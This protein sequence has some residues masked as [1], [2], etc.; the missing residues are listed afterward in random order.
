ML[1][2]SLFRVKQWIKNG[3][4]LVPL[5]FA[6]QFEDW[7]C[8]C[9]T[10]A[11]FLAF[12]FV[13]SFIY[14]INDIA[15]R[16]VDAAHP[17]KSKRPIASG[18]ISIPAAAV[19]GLLCLFITA[20]LTAW[21]GDSRF[22][23]A[24]S[25]YVALNLLYSWR[26]KYVQLVDVFCIAFGFVLRVYA[27]AYAISVPVSS[28]LFMVMLFLS[29]FLALGK[30]KSELINS[31]DSGTSSR[32]ILSGYSGATIDKYITLLA[33][34]VIISYALYTLDASTLAKFGNRLIYSVVFVI[35]GIFRYMAQLDKSG[36][37]DDPTDNLYGDNA[38]IAVCV[39]FMAY[40]LAVGAG[41]I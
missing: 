36:D 6:L 34:A 12:C 5:V 18:K 23:F 17:K 40:I 15:D 2:I 31:I 10:F 26:L 1:V 25:G 8:L 7:R 11:A 37:Y 4:V 3:F 9:R 22:L 13:S 14:I 29:L 32:K 39:A 38:L 33:S 20:G 21:L 24:V 30:R 27:G 19:A 16:K 41:I 35:Y 28:F